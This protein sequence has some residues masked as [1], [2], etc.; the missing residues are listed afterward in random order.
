MWT[1]AY[2]DRAHVAAL[3][4]PMAEFEDFLRQ[5]RDDLAAGWELKD[6]V[7]ARLIATIGHGLGFPTWRSLHQENMDDVELADL[8]SGWVACIL[9]Q[10]G[11]MSISRDRGIR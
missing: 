2:C 4:A 8:V 3:Q 7:G 9:Q 11:M 1:Q 10:N 6:K 5:V